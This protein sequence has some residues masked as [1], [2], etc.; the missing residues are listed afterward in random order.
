[1]VEVRLTV[2]VLVAQ[3]AVEHLELLEL[4]TLAVAV[5]EE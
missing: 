3:V 2:A 1:V 4:Q 5:V